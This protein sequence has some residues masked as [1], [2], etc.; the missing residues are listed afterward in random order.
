MP[1]FQFGGSSDSEDD[2]DDEDDDDEEDESEAVF[3]PPTNGH[4]WLTTSVYGSNEFNLLT[5]MIGVGL[6]NGLSVYSEVSHSIQGDAYTTLNGMFGT[7]YAVA[8]YIVPSMR[9]ERAQTD[10]GAEIITVEA[11]VASLEFFPI[12]FVEIRPEYRIVKT[13]AY[14]FGQPT[15]QLHIFY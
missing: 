4:V 1:H 14:V 10:T 3:S 5:G 7:A 2:W 9:V 12:P 15:V 8:D 13:K 6:S 11:F